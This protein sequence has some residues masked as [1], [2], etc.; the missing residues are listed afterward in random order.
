MSCNATKKI[1]NRIHK[2]FS[3]WPLHVSHFASSLST[4]TRVPGRAACALLNPSFFSPFSFLLQGTPEAKHTHVHTYLGYLLAASLGLKMADNTRRVG[5][6]AR[7]E[8]HQRV[9]FAFARGVF[10]VHEICGA[11]TAMQL[12][13]RNVL[14]KHVPLWKL[15]FPAVALHAMGNFRGKKPLFKVSIPDLLLVCVCLF[16]KNRIIRVPEKR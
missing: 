14:G 3:I 15:L 1:S 11:L 2:A 13:K 10:P 16:F 9:F 8:H 4:L 12:A 6:Y 7:P 5:L